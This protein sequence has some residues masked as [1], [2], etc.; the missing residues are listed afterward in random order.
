MKARHFSS[1]A[2]LPAVLLA[3]CTTVAIT[4]L[5]GS[6]RVSSH[7]G[8]VSIELGPQTQAVQ[9]ESSSIGYQQ[10]PLGFSLGI[11]HSSIAASSPG[12]R[13]IVWVKDAEQAYKLKETL[14]D[15]A[16]LCIIKANKETKP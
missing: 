14:G 5:D 8:F 7:F 3:G 16:E 12:C 15:P 11:N 4:D 9:A 6:T 1:F 2:A 13:L 10:G